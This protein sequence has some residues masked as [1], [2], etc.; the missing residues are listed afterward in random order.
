MQIESEI[1]K[2][3]SPPSESPL[4]ARPMIPDTGPSKHPKGYTAGPFIYTLL[5]GGLIATPMLLIPQHYLLS[6]RLRRSIVEM[7]RSLAV[8]RSE[9][10]LAEQRK[11]VEMG[12][13]VA[14]LRREAGEVRSAIDRT[15]KDMRGIGDTL[16]AG[17][18]DVKA[19]LGDVQKNIQGIRERFVN[20]DRLTQ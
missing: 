7:N 1:W 20:L 14:M 15:G 6:R 10:E 2:L 4:N 8:L 16:G 12:K 11:I 19:R 3:R 17:A 18:A 13:V 9:L 5:L